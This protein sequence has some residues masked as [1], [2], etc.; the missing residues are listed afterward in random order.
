[1][2]KTRQCL[3]AQSKASKS[4]TPRQLTY[5]RSLAMQRGESFAAPRSFAE[6]SAEIDRLKGR[7]R[8]SRAERRLESFQLRRDAASVGRDAA[9]VHESEIEGYGSSARWKAGR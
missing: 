6:A 3:T 8:L 5:L 7:R 2:T 1:M 4:P 9:S